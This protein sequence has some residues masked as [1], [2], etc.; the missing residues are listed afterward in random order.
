MGERNGQSDGAREAPR[1]ARPLLRWAGWAGPCL[2][3]AA[4]A[5]AGLKLLERRVLSMNAA[6]GGGAA[7]VC[8]TAAPQWM[9]PSVARRIAADLTP[10]HAR[11]S[12]AD[13]AR[14]AAALAA[15]HPWV[16]RALNVHVRVLN[17]GRG[18]IDVTAEFRR[19]VA[20]VRRGGDFA[21]VDAEGFVLPPRQ[22]P[23][24]VVG[25]HD[26]QGN[27]VRQITYAAAAEVRPEWRRAA[28]RI[29]YVLIEGVDG[30]PPAPG[31]RWDAPD[32]DD[33]LRLV[34][35]VR[36]RPFLAQVTVADVRNHGGRVSRSEP[37]L[38]LYAQ[39]GRGRPTEIRFGRFPVGS[40]DFVISP[41]RKMSYL[42]AYAADHGGRLAG[43]HDYIDLRFDHMHLSP[44]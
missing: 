24:Y 4:A 19:P 21:Y 25:F 39:I 13:L 38:R 23:Q 27:L 16:R 43:F 31:R 5:V 7:A 41:E 22:V 10:P 1:A 12:D 42:D 8:L 2:V 37:E 20:R 30:E 9:P 17:D 14:E 44:T 11:L 32:L 35:L 26:R 29:H 3:L 33:G 6:G 36:S 34:E 15:G 18:A 28:R 40:G